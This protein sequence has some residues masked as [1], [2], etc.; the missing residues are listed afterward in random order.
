MLALDMF[1]LD[2]FS[3]LPDFSHPT[4]KASMT[5][6]PMIDSAADTLCLMDNLPSA[7]LLTAINRSLTRML[8]VSSMPKLEIC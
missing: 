7:S 6:E 3:S 8:A 5:S 2:E 1:E 4:C